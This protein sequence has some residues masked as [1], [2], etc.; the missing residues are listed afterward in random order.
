MTT[1]YTIHGHPAILKNSK[2]IIR[3]GRS[4]IAIM[5]KAAEQ[6]RAL[7]I[8]QLKI[9]KAD[10]PTITEPVALTIITCIACRHGA[11][12]MP[13]ASNLY[14]FPEDLL[15]DAGIIENDSQVEHHDG[16]RRVCLCDGC[17]DYPC[18]AVKNCPYEAVNITITEV[19]T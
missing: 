10:K 1:T 2:R 3:R 4:H 11:G 7:A 15:Q 13:D 5:S 14:Q 9:Q 17:P 19:N 8:A 12:N 18:K 6:Y 16:S